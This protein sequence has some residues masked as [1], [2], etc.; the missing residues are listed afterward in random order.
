LKELIFKSAIAEISPEDFEHPGLRTCKFIFC[1]DQPNDNKMG[2]EYEDF[3][4]IRKSAI[5]TPVKMK[6][7]GAA[8]GGHLG[9]IPIGFIREIYENKGDDGSNQLIAV[10]TLFAD[11][12]PDE[13]EY[14]A[15]SYAEGRAP[16][17]S[18]EL[19]YSESVLKDGIEWLKGLVTRAATFVRN[20]AYGN[21]TAILALASNKEI[22]EDQMMQELS[23]LV[24]SNTDN[25]GGTVGMDEKELQAL[26]D[27]LAALKTSL[28]EKDTE[29]TTLNDKID[30]L[31]TAVSEK[32]ETINEYKAKETLTAR[33]TELA[34]AGITLPTDEAKLE[35]R[36]AYI[37]KL[38][39][40]AFAEYKESLVEIASTKVAPKKEGLAS[41]RTETVALP[42]FRAESESVT[43]VS[44]LRETLRN[45]RA[46]NAQSE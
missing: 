37:A 42:R 18:W 26:K 43:K 17:I 44:D 38:D 4:E 19:R 35:A 33:T 2:I 45:A 28:A 12:Y 16:G 36:L 6:F 20:P 7:F 21:R 11:E 8:A 5:G 15:H 10:A 31:T 46:R 39:D 9:S 23:E 32:D 13:I 14:L 3:A 24:D 27:E 41:L 22:D 30:T 34:E 25:E 29:I 40:E 1:D